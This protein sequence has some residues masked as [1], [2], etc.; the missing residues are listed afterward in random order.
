MANY[1]YYCVEHSLVVRFNKET[2]LYDKYLESGEWERC[3]D[4]W[5][6]ITNGR[7]IPTEAEAMATAQKIFER[8]RK[9]KAEGRARREE[10]MTQDLKY[11]IGKFQGEEGLSE[12]RRREM[13]EQIAETPAKVRAAVAGFTEQQY[14]TPYREGGWT[15]RQLVHHLADSHMNAYIRFKLALTEDEPTI[16]TYEQ[17]R[18]AETVDART[19]PAEISLLLLDGLHH[20]WAML[21]RAMNPADFAR[22][23][24]HLEHGKMTLERL[25]ALYAWHGRHHTAHVAGLRERMKW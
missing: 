8:D 7:W 3:H 10:R 11:P 17:E 15:V 22:K 18:W 2:G 23:F 14:D 25:L 12:A 21:L 24:H 9:W 6:V 13:I 16:K 5:D 1:S 20:R 19:A 4:S